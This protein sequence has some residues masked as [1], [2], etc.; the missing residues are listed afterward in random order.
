MPVKQYSRKLV[1]LASAAAL[2]VVS[3]GCSSK[4]EP[5]PHHIVE[6]ASV[7]ELQLL[8]K[9]VEAYDRGL[10]SISGETWR[11]L[12]DSYPTGYYGTLA[13]LKVADCFFYSKNF[14]EALVAYEEY[15]RL[16]QGSSS[17][18]YVYYQMANSLWMQYKDA[19]HDQGPLLAAVDEFKALI[20]KF[21]ESEYAERARTRLAE[22]ENE[23]ARHEA[24]VAEFYL[25]VGEYD[26]A[27]SRLITIEE[28]YP[29]SDSAKETREKFAEFFEGD[30]DH[31]PR[32]VRREYRRLP[33]TVAT[34]ESPI[35]DAPRVLLAN[36]PEPSARARLKSASELSSAQ[37]TPELAEEQEAPGLIREGACEE[38]GD[39]LAFSIA[40]RGPLS[41]GKVE[42]TGDTLSAKAISANGAENVRLQKTVSC[43]VGNVEFS[44]VEFLN[45]GQAEIEIRAEGAGTR[46]ASLISLDRPNRL[47]MLLAR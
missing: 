24:L 38:I 42:R 18:P 26:S 2:G 9:A 31:I 6:V 13:E 40:V 7:P 12:R 32:R 28:K 46:D 23:I 21:P 10:Y 34:T 1:Y 11:E 3:I 20:K 44:A 14:S 15:S 16:H 41:A 35:P 29:L 5:K 47:V 43:S 27:L 17:L 22:A 37:D 30:N 8:T 4:E 33:L 36:L 39:S 45:G 25:K 19:L